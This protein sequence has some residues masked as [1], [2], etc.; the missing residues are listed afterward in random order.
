M[1]TALLHRL[2]VSAFLGLLA[3]MLAWNLWLHPPEQGAL[4]TVALFTLV[5]P[6]LLVLR[7]I[8][9]GQRYTLA[10]S[11]IIVLIY[12]VHGVTHIAAPGPT[13][14]LSA[15]ELALVAAYFTATLMY[16]RHAS[17]SP[18]RPGARRES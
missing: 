16:L 1:D 8:L 15:L 13:R 17:G 5:G 3:L 4:R 6:L 12:F 2:A 11:A 10:W 14:A 9:Q 7:G 18:P